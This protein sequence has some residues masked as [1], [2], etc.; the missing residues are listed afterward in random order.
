[1][2]EIYIVNGEEFSLSSL[3][4]N[5]D[6]SEM[7]LQEYLSTIGAEL[8][9]STDQVEEVEKQEATKNAADF[10]AEDEAALESMNTDLTSET[11][12][13]DYDSEVQKINLSYRTKK[14]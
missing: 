4:A 3:Q 7:D 2:E 14:K 5:A 6:E 12:L 10:V 9:G 1:M 11:V 8:K 13:S